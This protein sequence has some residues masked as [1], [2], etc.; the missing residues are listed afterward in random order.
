MS[1]Q[2]TEMGAPAA[3]TE[4]REP[5]VEAEFVEASAIRRAPQG[6]SADSG[7]ARISMDLERWVELDHT[8]HE[9][10]NL[11]EIA[12]MQR[13]EAR[14]ATSKAEETGDLLMARL[15]EWKTYARVLEERLHAA[16]IEN[17]ELTF[18]VKRVGQIAEEALA[19]PTFSRARRR[20]LRE[21]LAD[22]GDEI[23]G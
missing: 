10:Y 19:T 7:R 21:R 5:V 4:E 22:A 16:Q 23:V 18:A 6:A 12:I 1:T 13:D 3:R 20:K 9:L 15:R 17:L 14:G 2:S 8:L 11:V